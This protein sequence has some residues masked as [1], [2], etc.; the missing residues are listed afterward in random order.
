ME[1]VDFWLECRVSTCRLMLLSWIPVVLALM[2]KSKSAQIGDVVLAICWLGNQKT[3]NNI[4]QKNP[5]SGT[6]VQVAS[7]VGFKS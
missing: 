2:S 5:N 7:T 3:G 1:L 4:S 6:S